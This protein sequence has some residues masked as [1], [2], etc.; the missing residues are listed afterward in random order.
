MPAVCARRLASTSGELRLAAR[1]AR[2]VLQLLRARR[3]ERRLLHSAST[4]PLAQSQR[5]ERAVCACIEPWLVGY[6]LLP[7][8]RLIGRARLRR[9][10][11]YAC[12][13]V[14]S[15]RSAVACITSVA[16]CRRVRSAAG[17]MWPAVTGCRGGGGDG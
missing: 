3:P 13:A 1:P 11:D 8:P 2:P 10:A 14:A 5:T 6:G 15:V 9:I 16:G 7:R 12:W 17:L 4:A